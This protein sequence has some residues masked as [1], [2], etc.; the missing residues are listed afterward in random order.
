MTVAEVMEEFRKLPREE[1][2]E[3]FRVLRDELAGKPSPEQIAEFERRAERLRRN[4]E[5]GIPWEQVQAELKE[6]LEARRACP[7]K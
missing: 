2:L 4:P 3:V 6:R 1:Q 7:V 5:I